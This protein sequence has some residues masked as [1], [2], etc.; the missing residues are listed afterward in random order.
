MEQRSKH[1]Q[2]K[3]NGNNGNRHTPLVALAAVRRRPASELDGATACR[4]G[5]R[6]ASLGRESTQRGVDLDIWT[7]D[8]K[9]MTKVLG[10][11]RSN[12]LPMGAARP[13][14]RNGSESALNDTKVSL[15]SPAKLERQQWV[16]ALRVSQVLV[17][18]KESKHSLHPTAQTRSAVA[19]SLGT[20]R[21]TTWKGARAPCRQCQERQEALPHGE[22]RQGC[23]AIVP[24]SRRQLAPVS[25]GGAAPPKASCAVLVGS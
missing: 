7:G 15:G 14:Q 18:G 8:G 1:S 6:C 4:A 19:K 17:L 11:Q 13:C 10:V 21:P 12:R 22:L 9:Q 25:D 24:E 5:G 23:K 3:G 16:R 20:R 2:Q